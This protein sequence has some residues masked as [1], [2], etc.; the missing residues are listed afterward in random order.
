MKRILILL[1]LWTL[2]CSSRFARADLVNAIEAIV[3]DSVITYLEVNAHY[4]QAAETQARTFIGPRTQLEEKLKAMERET[5]DE[6]VQRQLI[7]HEFKTAGYNLPE[8]V[9]DDLVN[10]NIKADF[11]DRA[12]LTKTLEARGMTYEK[13]RQ[14]IRERFIVAQL[15]LKNVSQ[16][17]I[18]SPHKIEAYYLAHREDYKLEDEVRY[19]MIAL[20]KSSDPNVP[21]PRELAEEILRK[22]NEG[23]PFAEMATIYSQDSSHSQG[24]DRGWVEKSGLRKELA[25]A[26]FSLK[27]GQ[28]SGV[29]DTP[30]VFYLVL[31]EDAR[32]AHYKPLSEVR[33]QIETDLLADERTRITKKW[34]DRL[35]KKTFV[36]QFF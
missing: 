13:F 17:I 30:E 19:R 4:E 10:E 2:L 31:V 6:L 1:V 20:N 15:R 18:V 14:Q 12:T 28:H 34:M 35:R 23:A 32:A 9:L 11:G 8:T 33:Q 21:Q 7:L 29:I 25:E 5:L 22:L 24:G 26:A 27:P 3:D 16:E 36:N